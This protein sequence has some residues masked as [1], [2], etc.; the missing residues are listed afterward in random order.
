MGFHLPAEMRFLPEKEIEAIMCTACQKRRGYLS[1]SFVARYEFLFEYWE[2]VCIELHHEF[3]HLFELD[4]KDLPEK[5][6]FENS[7]GKITIGFSFPFPWIKNESKNHD[8]DFNGRFLEPTPH[9]YV[10]GIAKLFEKELSLDTNYFV[11][12]SC[13]K[14][15]GESNGN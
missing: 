15:K 14:E 10:K 8:R 1:P 13:K 9:L 12:K 6:V 11:K 7:L 3:P 4:T 5:I 2:K